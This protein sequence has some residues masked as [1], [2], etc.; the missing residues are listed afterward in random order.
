MACS[1]L[2]RYHGEETQP[3]KYQGCTR[4]RVELLGINTRSKYGEKKLVTTI[5]L[6]PLSTGLRGKDVGALE[7]EKGGQNRRGSRVRLWVISRCAH[8]HV[9][10][11]IIGSRERS[12]NYPLLGPPTMRL[13]R[14]LSSQEEKRSRNARGAELDAPKD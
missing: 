2:K 14:Y 10:T 7:G 5:S 9:P 13:T 12:R 3:D 8:F 1:A 11:I 6:V 4:E